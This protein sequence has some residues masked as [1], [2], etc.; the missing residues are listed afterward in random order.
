MLP[1]SGFK[2]E[3][4]SLWAHRPFIAIPLFLPYHIVISIPAH[5]ELM[6]CTRVPRLA[7]R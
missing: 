2:L 1:T 4:A 3:L 7:A 5:D 6:V